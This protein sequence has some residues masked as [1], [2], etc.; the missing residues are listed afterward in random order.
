[1]LLFQNYAKFLL[2]KC[3]WQIQ[4]Y[5]RISKSSIKGNSGYVR[6]TRSVS[7]SWNEIK[8]SVITFKV[9]TQHDC[10]ERMEFGIEPALFVLF[11]VRLYCLCVC[12]LFCC[13]LIICLIGFVCLFFFYFVC[14]VFLFFVMLNIFRI[15]F[16]KV[17]EHT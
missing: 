12:L 6:M 5:I 8:T 4:Q 2:N 17:R 10:S 11:F 13:C 9:I 15:K 16:I 7:K 3:L 14:Q 1:M